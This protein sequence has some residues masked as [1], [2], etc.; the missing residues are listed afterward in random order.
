MRGKT[1]VITGASSGL[2]LETARELAKRGARVVMVVRNRDKG[3]RVIDEIVRDAQDAQLE[4]AI[5]DLYS[6]AAVREVG[7]ELRRRFPK[8]DVLVNN[9][10]LIHDRRELTVDGFERT[11]ALNH[12]AAFLLTHELREPLAA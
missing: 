7:A 3:Q 9:A 6:L 8:I 4:L 10:G 11:F 1:V 12:L 5:A 2:G